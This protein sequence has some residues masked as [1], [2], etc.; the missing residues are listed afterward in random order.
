MNRVVQHWRRGFTLVELLVV[1]AIIGVLV[2]LL[3]PA[4]QAARE[5]ARRSSCQNNLKQIGLGMQ[6][7]HAAKGY[8]PYGASDGDCEAGTSPRKL[9]TWRTLL[10]PYMEQKTLYDQLVPLA[11]A[12]AGTN[13]TNPE[14]R[15][16]DLSPLQLQSVPAFVC[17]AEQ[18][19]IGNNMDTWFGP[20]TAAIASY[21]GNAGPVST[22][23]MDWGAP[24]VCGNC[25]GNIECLCD[26]G[27][28]AG[29]NKRGFLHGHNPDGPGMLDMY[30]NEISTAQV[31][32][33]TSNTI[34]VGESH[35]VEPDA[36]Q[37]GCFGN[38]Q[39]MATFAVASS[40]WGINTD[41]IAKTGMTADQHKTNNYLTGCN[42]RSRHPGGAQFLFVD[43]S[44]RF[45]E[46]SASPT[47][48]SN[49]SNR[50]DGNVG[51]E[52]V[53]PTTPGGGR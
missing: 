34:H 39:W 8:F 30:A 33:G 53:R 45:L 49:L 31:P 7:H 43:G 18:T 50:K 21:F 27:N 41:Y 35:W 46:E 51:E 17:P 42:F 40:V 10:L 38:M 37:P 4:V 1:I 29:P 15:Q 36:Y 14:Q 24:Y 47:L 16:W 25:L 26:T 52:Y 2:A 19:V 32:D 20:P 11:K 9:W 22:G 5:A 6:N 44:V 48:L 23:P 28:D 12:S 3:L 13:C